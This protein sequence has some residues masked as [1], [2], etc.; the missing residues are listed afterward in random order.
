[1][2]QILILIIFFLITS[3]STKQDI[4]KQRIITSTITANSEYEAK[5]IAQTFY[6][7][8]WDKVRINGKIVTAI[9]YCE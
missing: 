1:M 9:E 7:N 4:V 2:K 8:G 6:K 5:N 3:C